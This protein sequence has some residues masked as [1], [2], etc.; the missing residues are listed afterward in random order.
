VLQNPFVWLAPT[1]KARYCRSAS[2]TFLLEPLAPCG[3]MPE[4]LAPKEVSSMNSKVRF[5]ITGEP[6]P[7]CLLSFLGWFILPV[8]RTSMQELLVPC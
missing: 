8:S 7:R 1:L 5:L 3:G 4:L 2:S 6:L